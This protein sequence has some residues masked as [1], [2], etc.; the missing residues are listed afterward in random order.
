MLDDFDP[1]L[2]VRYRPPTKTDDHRAVP[3]EIRDRYEVGSISLWDELWLKLRAN[4]KA[5]LKATNNYGMDDQDIVKCKPNDGVTAV[6]GLLTMYKSVG[7]AYREE[8]TTKLE[9]SV[10]KFSNGSIPSQVVGDL[11]DVLTKCT[12]LNVKQSRKGHRD[13]FD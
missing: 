9:T 3:K 8:L 10:N 7:I 12:E 4:A 5:R 1:A 11:K 2:S 13:A 6:F